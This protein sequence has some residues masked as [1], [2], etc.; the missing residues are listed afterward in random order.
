MYCTINDV[1]AILP[2]PITVGDTNIG[3]P[4]PGRPNQANKDKLTPDEVIRYI[5]FAQNEIDSRLRPYYVVPLRRI[6]SFETEIH[7]NVSPGSNVD[8]RVHD[9]GVFAKGQMVRL[10]AQDHMETA[11]VASIKHMTTIVLDSVKYSYLLDESL[12]S[13]LEM[14]DPVPLIAARLAA[15]YAFD[16]LFSADQSPNIS[17]YGKAQRDL[18]INA[19]ASILSGAVLLFGQDHTGRRFVRGSLFDAY[20]NPTPDFQFGREK[21]S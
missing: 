19:M 6:K 11:E 15:S 17:E 3:T 10:Q 14:P 12:I 7:G 8:V 5:R 1:K 4:F 9:S 21:G 2:E 16:Q 20:N 18:A 13:I